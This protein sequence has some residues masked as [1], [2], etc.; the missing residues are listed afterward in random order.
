MSEYFFYM[1]SEPGQSLASALGASAAD[2]TALL[3]FSSLLLL[4]RKLRSVAGYLVVAACV[5]VKTAVLISATVLVLGQKDVDAGHPRLVS[6]SS[7]CSS[8]C[9]SAGV[10]EAGCEVFCSCILDKLQIRYWDLVRIA[11]R[12][13]VPALA[14]VLPMCRDAA[15]ESEQN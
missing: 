2:F 11:K 3:V 15:T 13:P 1:T 5:S 10:S 7:K 9:P 6:T 14:G 4:W 12:E 8:S